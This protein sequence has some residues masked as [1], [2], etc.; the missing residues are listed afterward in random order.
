MGFKHGELGALGDVG[1]LTEVPEDFRH[2]IAALGRWV[3]VP[4]GKVLYSVGDAPDALYGVGKGLIDISVPIDSDEQ[5]TVFRAAPGFWIG[6]GS[7]LS[8]MPRPLTITAPVDS[9]LFRVPGTALSRSLDANPGDWRHLHRLAGQ[10]GALAVRM[11]AEALALPPRVRF[12]RLLIRI[13]TP[14]GR[15][16]CTQEDLG[17]LAGM[18]RAAFRRAFASL[19][20]A[21]AVE[22]GRGRVRILDFGALKAEAGKTWE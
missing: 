10:N 17:R 8:D 19:I 18:S 15:V 1:W 22:T 13:A 14:D 20:E 9:M 21:G 16:D 6:D 12:A 3:A 4:R 2:R 11:L 7:L 5:I